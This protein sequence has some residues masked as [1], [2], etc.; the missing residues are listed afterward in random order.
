MKILTADQGNTFLKFTLFDDDR[1][2]AST[3]VKSDAPEEVLPIV[4]EWSPDGGIFSSVGRFD[5]R[6]VET[7]RKL[8][9]DRLLVLTPHTPLP[10]T[11][12]YSSRDTLGVDRLAAAAGAAMIFPGDGCVVAD[13]G[14]ALT[15]DLLGGDGSFKGGR[16]SPGVFMRIKALH[17]FTA[18]LPLIEKNGEI[19]VVGKS[20]ETSLRSGIIYGMAHELAGAPSDYSLTTPVRRLVLT[21]GDADLLEPYVRKCAESTGGGFEINNVSNLLNQGLLYIFKYNLERD[22]V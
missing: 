17:N 9:C 21:G 18:R 6:F 8:V 19:P 10:L 3:T 13:C 7:L 11:V 12:D 15:V 22:G 14:S 16:I 4:D 2:V 20:T 1:E 5:I